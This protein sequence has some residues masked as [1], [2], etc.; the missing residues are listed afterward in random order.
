MLYVGKIIKKLREKCLCVELGNYILDQSINSIYV[1]VL[2]NNNKIWQLI[3]TT[4]SDYFL[5]VETQ[6]L[7][8]STFNGILDDSVYLYFFKNGKLIKKQLMQTNTIINNFPLYSSDIAA[9]SIKFPLQTSYKNI[10][11]EPT[12]NINFFS[13]LNGDQNSTIGIIFSSQIIN[14][15]TPT[16]VY[17]YYNGIIKTIVQG[18]FIRAEAVEPANGSSP[19]GDEPLLIDV[20]NYFIF[21]P[22]DIKRN[23]DNF[24]NTITAQI[25]ITS[26]SG[27]VIPEISSFGM[28][29]IVASYNGFINIATNLNQTSTYGMKIVCSLNTVTPSPLPGAN[30]DIK[31]QVDNG[32]LNAFAVARSAIIPGN[33]GPVLI[34]VAPGSKINIGMISVD[35]TNT[36]KFNG[37]MDLIFYLYQFPMPK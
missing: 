35:N 17:Y 30:F 14:N 33:S 1:G 13:P 23:S 24:I 11:V 18:S 4:N 9:G 5:D 2:D 7:Y 8:N 37:T 21:S 12:S 22:N 29:G 31:Y 6:K 34:P 26:L 36:I 19:E 27:F 28:N 20:L 16:F 32:G 25:P 3:A 15:V 10:I